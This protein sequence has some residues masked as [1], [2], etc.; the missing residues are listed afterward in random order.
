M[1]K[2]F[3]SLI[4]CVGLLSFAAEQQ[5]CQPLTPTAARPFDT[6][7]YLPLGNG[8]RPPNTVHAPSPDF[9]EIASKADLRTGSVALAL[10][11]NENGTIEA[12]KVVRSSDSRFE[13]TAIDTVRQWAFTP[14]TRDG[15]PV[16][17]QMNVEVSFQ[18]H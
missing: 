5:P 7:R 11:L 13:P 1:T 16:A 3:A 6:C 2:T 4:I 8:I 10:A 18:L 9:S 14:A 12:V 17:V 15:K